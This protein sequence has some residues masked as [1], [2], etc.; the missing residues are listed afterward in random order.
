MV[1]EGCWREKKEEIEGKLLAVQNE[2]LNGE[3]E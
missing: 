3:T 1:V 2:A